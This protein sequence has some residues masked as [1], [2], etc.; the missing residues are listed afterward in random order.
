MPAAH[1]IPLCVI[2]SVKTKF[3]HKPQAMVKTT[4]FE[5][6]RNPSKSGSAF[7]VNQKCIST[8]LFTCG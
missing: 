2:P 4:T 8:A 3:L 1:R 6:M 5:K 7:Y